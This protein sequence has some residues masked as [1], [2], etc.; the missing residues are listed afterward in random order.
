LKLL[1][2]ARRNSIENI[3]FLEIRLIGLAVKAAI[4]GDKF[5]I[6]FVSFRQA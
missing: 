2:V 6:N 1:G 3:F 5:Y 4:S